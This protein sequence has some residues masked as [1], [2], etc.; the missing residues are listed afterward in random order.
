MKKLLFLI[1]FSFSSILVCS[2]PIIQWQK[3][4][5][6]SSD[7]FVH[8]I[9]SVNDGG[10]IAIGG[11]LSNDGD[12]TGNHGGFDCWVVKLTENG[13]LQWQKSLGG[14]NND[15]AYSIQQTNDGGYI[16]AGLSE[17]NDGDVSGNYGDRDYWIIKLSEAGNIQWER[18]LGGSW[19][20]EAWSIIQT[21]EG[22]YIVAGVSDSQDGEVTGN[23]GNEDIW[24]VKLTELGEVQWQKSFGGSGEDYANSIQQTSD[25]GYIVAGMSS[26][27]NGDV[28]ANHGNRDCWIL[29][30]SVIGEIQWEKALGG[31]AQ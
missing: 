12:V 27:Y 6:G 31:S 14:L 1:A 9:Q 20:D 17:S 25:G 21:N 5:G 3:S 10:Y 23:H 19:G 29:K 11:S 26:S 16:I 22:G 8:S 15:V 4:F 7:D 24:I 18:N 13:S 2:Q 28:S 30:L